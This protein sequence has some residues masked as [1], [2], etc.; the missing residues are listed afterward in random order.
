MAD[1]FVGTRL[2]E[3]LRDHVCP[4]GDREPDELGIVDRCEHVVDLHVDELFDPVVSKPLELPARSESPEGSAVA[5]RVLER[6]ARRGEE[7]PPFQVHARDRSLHEDPE[8]IRREPEPRAPLEECARVGVGRRAREHEEGHGPAD[9]PRQAD[10][11]L[12]L[13]LVDRLPR[14]RHEREAALRAGEAEAR[15]FPARDHEHANL[16]TPVG[17]V[18]RRSERSCLPEPVCERQNRRR[19][20]SVQRERF[21]QPL[22]LVPVELDRLRHYTSRRSR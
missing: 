2:L 21:G 9:A 20:G 8:L 1:P 11:L 14:M 12:G 5:V 3:H 22:P 4:L 15:A 17:V 16:S 18:A 7:R 19:L 6:C 13:E 10:D